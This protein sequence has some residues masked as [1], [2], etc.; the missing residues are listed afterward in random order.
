MDDPPIDVQ[1][2]R[3]AAEI[4][5]HFA[6]GRLSNDELEASLPSTHDWALNDIFFLGILPLYD[7]FHEH[8]LV[9][10]YRLTPEG[11]RYVAR[12]VLF[13]RGG[14]PYRWPRTTGLHTLRDDLVALLTLGLYRP[15]L[16]RWCACGGDES[17]WP[18]FSRSEYEDAL[19]RPNLLAGTRANSPS[20]G[21]DSGTLGF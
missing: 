3:R 1:A 4:F 7:D 6:A 17:V 14:R 18:F 10:P 21:A 9:G 13:L 11:R 8:R 20:A 12:I 15:H 16:R 19:R 2:R 5:R